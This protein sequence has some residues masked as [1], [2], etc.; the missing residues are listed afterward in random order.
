MRTFHRQRFT[1][2]KGKIYP[3]DWLQTRPYTTADA[4]DLY[5]VSLANR[6]MAAMKNSVM[7]DAF[8]DEHHIRLSA[9]FLTEWFEDLCSG[10]HIWET[11]NN[12]YQKR[13]GVMLPFYDMDGY[14]KGEVNVQ[15]L[16]L[17]LWDIIQTGRYDEGRIIN[18]EN[19]GIDELARS[20]F[21]IF[22][23]EY[24]YAP[25][26][27]RLRDFILNPAIKKDLWA[28]RDWANWFTFRCYINHDAMNC[29]VE[30]L[31]E[32]K[33]HSEVLLYGAYAIHSLSHR[34]NLLSLSS[35]QWA[36]R[37][38]QDSLFEKE[39]LLPARPY[40]L[41]AIA[42]EG[43]H[44]Q[45]LIEDK[46]LLI[47]AESLNQKDI[48]RKAYH[49]GQSV[50][51]CTLMSMNDRFYL[52]GAMHVIDRS[53]PKMD[54]FLEQ[55]R[56]QHRLLSTQDQVYDLFLEANGGDDLF[57]AEDYQA[58]LRFYTKT[59]GWKIG[60]NADIPEEVRH[61]SHYLLFADPKSGIQIVPNMARCVKLPGNP[62]YDPA[63]ARKN[64]SNPFFSNEAVSYRLSCRLRD[65]DLLPDA[66]M[67]SVKGEEYG[68]Q[69]LHRNGDFFADYYF[70]CCREYDFEPFYRK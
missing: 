50:L 69:F 56:E 57:V 3:N 27:D 6:V 26:N 30:Q 64:A 59:L 35:P 68:R 54:E 39:A 10:T 18:P 11:V 25:G 47:D 44:V 16:K 52:C 21:E 12:E 13:Y 42:A 15:D 41:Q 58:I 46:T 63:F 2:N 61:R 20:L 43:L 33:E 36:S 23:Q 51:V 37:L 9:M 38:L 28:F 62:C 55:Q 70:S 34:K 49:E 5:Y 48:D 29:L 22:D 4:T 40:L 65:R 17:L 60:D 14:V 67:N 1:F 24:E 19:P 32:D 31:D 45:D 53:D 8:L 66:W 7:A